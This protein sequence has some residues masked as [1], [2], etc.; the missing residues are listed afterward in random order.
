MNLAFASG[1]SNALRISTDGLGDGALGLE[2]TETQEVAAVELRDLVNNV[3][4]RVKADSPF[5]LWCLPVSAS[6]QA[7][8]AWEDEYQSTCLLPQWS[9]VVE[10]TS[11]WKVEISLAIRRL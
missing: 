3:L 1:I 6:F 11:N 5:L 10:P 8:S 4:L 9:A 7:G 2:P